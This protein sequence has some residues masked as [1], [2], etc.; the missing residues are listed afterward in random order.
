MFEY[1]GIL[2]NEYT[3]LYIYTI[4]NNKDI[5]GG[6]LWTDKC[7]SCLFLLQVNFLVKTRPFMRSEK[8]A[9]KEV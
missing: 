9:T 5:L 3:F 7:L 8:S 4:Y 6:S 1:E 2:F